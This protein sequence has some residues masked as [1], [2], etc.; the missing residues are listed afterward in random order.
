MSKYKLYLRLHDV[1]VAFLK[2]KN[3]RVCKGNFS[4][5]LKTYLDW[6]FSFGFFYSPINHASNRH[7]IP[8]PIGKSDV[9]DQLVHVACYKHKQAKTRLQKKN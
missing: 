9:I 6:S 2:Q 8:N 1:A 3:M 7:A 4:D 5:V